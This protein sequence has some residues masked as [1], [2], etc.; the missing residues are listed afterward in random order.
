MWETNRWDDLDAQIWSSD[1][2]IKMFEEKPPLE[3]PCCPWDSVTFGSQAWPWKQE[4]RSTK[5]PPS[6]MFHSNLYEIAQPCLIWHQTRQVSRP[7]DKAEDWWLVLKISG[8]SGSCFSLKV[9]V[10]VKNWSFK[11]QAK[12]VHVQP[13][14]RHRRGKGFCLRGFLGLHEGSGSAMRKKEIK[15]I[16]R[17]L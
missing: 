6:Q 1:W 5:I 8:G 12:A 9:I 16:W 13:E 7:F 11:D 3:N 15:E 4:H 10:V 2:I 17:S 14:R